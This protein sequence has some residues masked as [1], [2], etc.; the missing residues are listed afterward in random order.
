MNW[1]KIDRQQSHDILNHIAKVSDPHLFSL[2]S[3]ETSFFSPPF[4]KDYFV[5]RVTNFA[6]LPS[7][8]LDFLSNG[9]SY[10]L[11]DGSPTPINTVNKSGALHLSEANVIA[12]T[13]FYLSNIR[14]DDGDIYM[15]NDMESLPFID[16]LGA[17]QQLNLKQN[18][19]SPVAKWDAERGHYTIHADLFYGGTLIKSVIY[20]DTYG[21][22]EIQPREMIM[23]SKIDFQGKTA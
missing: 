8:S 22:L 12:Y 14:G 17:D 10:Y 20:V 6:T 11:L 9:E 23:N 7:F 5:Y 2:Q 18:H 4:Y 1:Q 19:E 21:I 13:E 16:S 3:S 15:I